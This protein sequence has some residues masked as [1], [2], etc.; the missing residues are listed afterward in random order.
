MTLQNDILMVCS[1]HPHPYSFAPGLLLCL[2]L[3]LITEGG[4]M[5]SHSLLA[6]RQ[7][8]HVFVLVAC[9]PDWLKSGSLEC[10]PVL[11]LQAELRTALLPHVY[12]AAP[13]TCGL[14]GWAQDELYLQSVLLLGPWSHTVSR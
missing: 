2:N 11:R 8:L 7:G 14:C 3:V 1:P 9:P 10:N 4:A 13:L 12:P 5:H 6:H